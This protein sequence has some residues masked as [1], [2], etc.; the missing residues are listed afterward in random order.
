[1]NNYVEKLIVDGVFDEKWVI[2]SVPLTF[3]IDKGNSDEKK[4]LNNVISN[5]MF[6]LTII[7]LMKFT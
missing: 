6:S 2:R 5:Y 3:K 7:I 1:V 4:I